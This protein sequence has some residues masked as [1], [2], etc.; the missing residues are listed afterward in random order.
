MSTP[1]AGPIPSVEAMAGRREQM[2]PAFSVAQVERIARFGRRQELAPGEIL[3]DEGQRGVP[4]YVIT[5]GEVEIVHPRDGVEDL[6]T[7]H[8]PREFTGEMSMLAGRRGLVRGRARGHSVVLRVE[9]DDFRSLVQSDAEIS[10]IVMRAFILRR[11]GLL[12]GRHGDAV[13]LGSRH[14]AATLRV[15][16]FLS[17][18]GHPYRYVDVDLDADVQSLLD[19]FHVA[20]S[21]VPVLICRGTRVLK[22]PSNAEVADCLGFNEGVTVGTVRDVVVVGAG[23]AGLSAAVYAASEGL[24]VLMIEANSPGGQAGS[25]SKIE[26]YLGFP[27]GISGQALA[28][29]ALSQAEKFGAQITVARNAVKL[30]CDTE[31][32]GIELEGGEIVRTR[33]VVIAT[34]VQY[35]KLEVP[36]LAR[37][38]GVGIYYGA[39]FIEAQRC[40][41]DEVVVVGGGN[42]AGQAATFLARSSSHVHILVRGAGLAAT[43]SRYLTRRIEETP[44]ITLHTGSNIVALEGEDALESVTWQDGSGQRFT[45]PIRHVFSMAGASPNTQWLQGCLQLDDK[46]FVL[47][48]R[49]VASREIDGEQGRASYAPHLFET[50]LPRVFAV[51][52]V[53]ASSVKRVASAVGEGSVCIQ[54]VHQVLAG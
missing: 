31:P 25:S 11:M 47:T 4:F 5:E 50:S 39:T 24:D 43:M 29:R 45:R 6:V 21:D 32:Y 30:H 44:N 7:V 19:G 37:F 12:A 53:R 16:E 38:E 41:A 34:G 52:D 26:N 10:E 13:L 35:R 17:R 48:G 23:P 2:F 40:E 1:I 27:T 8:Q 36:N 14:S 9:P 22:N 51:G 18:N 46:G 33:A 49:D 20:I 3:F 15:Q 54:L 42:S 28:G